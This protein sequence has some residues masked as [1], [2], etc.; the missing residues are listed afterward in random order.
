ME[1][2]KNKQELISEAAKLAILHQQ[3]RESIIKI[4][5]DL[6]KEDKISSNHLEGIATV[7][8]LLK[9]LN[10]LEEEHTLILEQIKGK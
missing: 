9:E 7:N 8:E 4:F 1:P 3:K 2:K 6:D 5:N 10:V